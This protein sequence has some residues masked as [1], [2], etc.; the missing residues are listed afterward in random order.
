M[1]D[2]VAVLAR[3]GAEAFVFGMSSGAVLSLEA[4]RQGVLSARLAV[5]EP[6]V[7]PGG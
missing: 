5:Y 7:H 1:E 6:F 3:V 2:L 4:A